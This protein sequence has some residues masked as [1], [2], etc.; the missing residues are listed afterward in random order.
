MTATIETEC[1]EQARW[2]LRPEFRDMMIFDKLVQGEF[3]PPER[4][5]AV[6][7]RLR[8]QDGMLRVWRVP[9]FLGIF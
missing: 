4:Q 3:L 1:A 9:L 7:A 2:R 8:A 6:A 5:Q